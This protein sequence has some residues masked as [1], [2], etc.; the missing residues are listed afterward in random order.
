M[1]W[2]CRR[3]AGERLNIISDCCHRQTG[4]TNVFFARKRDNDRSP[5]QFMFEIDDEQAD[6]AIVGE[7]L[8]MIGERR[9]DGS[10][11]ARKVGRFRIAP[12]GK[13]VR[14][15][16]LPAEW[17]TGMQSRMERGMKLGPGSGGLR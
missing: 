14:F 3:E 10:Q 5:A 7:V 8:E 2:G 4:M 16:F 12:N 1:G 13:V 6:G 11:S 15:P 17:R 9:P